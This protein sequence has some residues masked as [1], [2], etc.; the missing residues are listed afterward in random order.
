MDA[1]LQV[2]SHESGAE[3]QNP[4]PRPAG[5]ASLDAAQDMICFLIKTLEQ[6]IWAAQEEE[7]NKFPAGKHK[8]LYSEQTSLCWLWL[9]PKQRSWVQAG[10]WCQHEGV[11]RG[12]ASRALMAACCTPALLGCYERGCSPLGQAALAATGATWDS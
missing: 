1:G 3:G 9:S 6:S 10:P 11:A 8:S 5:H 7:D 2:G 4:L 12:A